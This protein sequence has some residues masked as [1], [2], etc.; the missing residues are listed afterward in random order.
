MTND[1]SIFVWRGKICKIIFG[2]N[3]SI[4]DW[5]FGWFP[6][7]AVVLYSLVSPDKLVG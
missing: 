2:F 6:S 4:K 3:E 7:G 5:L 1:I